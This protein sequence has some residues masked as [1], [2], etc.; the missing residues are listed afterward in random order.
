MADVARTPPSNSAQSIA[1]SA[2]V[3]KS[4]SAHSFGAEPT[5]NLSISPADAALAAIRKKFDKV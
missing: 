2:D 1:K 4:P 3:V 5:T